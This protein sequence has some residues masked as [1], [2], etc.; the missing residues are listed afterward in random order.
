[1][2]VV[3]TNDEDVNFFHIRKFTNIYFFNI[4]R[5][6]TDTSAMIVILKEMSMA[7]ISPFNYL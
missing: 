6:I 2:Q 1:M 7:I 5:T 4:R 3:G